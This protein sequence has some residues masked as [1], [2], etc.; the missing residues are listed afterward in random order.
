[1]HSLRP[2]HRLRLLLFL[3]AVLAPCMILV[4]LS[5][6][7]VRQEREL[8]EKRRVDEQRQLAREIRNDLAARLEAIQRDEIRTDLEPGQSYRHRE[9]ALVAWLDEDK[10]V[11]PWE[12]DR[13]A[14]TSRDLISKADFEPALRDC[15]RSNLVAG[16]PLASACF[17]QVLAAAKHP[18]QA[19]YA[20]FLWAD[21][22]DRAGERARAEGPFRALLNAGPELTDEDG[23]PLNLHAAQRFAESGTHRKEVVE[24]IRAALA[25][26]WLPPVACFLVSQVAARLDRPPAA[27][28]EARE[29][30]EAAAA[31]VRLVEQA[32]SLQNDFAR[33]G[34]LAV[35]GRPTPLWVSYG[36]ERW[37]VGAT[38]E[39]KP[40]AVIAVRAKELF[41]PIETR[42][43]VRF[44]AAGESLGDTFP[45]LTIVP[46]SAV[47][48]SASGDFERQ[49][50]FFT[51]LLV[52]A[53]TA[54]GAYLLWRDLRREM[55]AVELRAQFVASVSHELRTPLTAIRMFAETLQMGRSKDP[56]T[57]SEYL[58]TI[59][60]ECERLSRLVDGVL[61]FAKLEQ[62]KK[63]YHFRSVPVAEAVAAAVRALRYPLSQ[64][65][66][67]LQLS[68]EPDPLTIR[69]DRDALEQA[70]LNLLTNAMKYSGDAR[71]IE[72]SLFR[73][74]GDAVIRVTDHGV[75][76][77]PEAR[78]RI[79]EK[80][81][82]APT[83][84]NQL[85]PGTGLGLALVAH[86]VKAHGGRVEVESAP[87][88]GSTF[89]LHLPL[90]S[91]L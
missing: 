77:A 24:R 22:L 68:V 79:F 84:E 63:T 70:I 25:R 48:P 83:P 12:R 32:Q 42:R 59:V 73:H 41:Q 33:L 51:V 56:E 18:A 30:K 58:E 52:A 26:P 91:K 85:I 35:D 78:L 76:I 28:A 1:M 27:A 71:Q 47:T 72:L 31:H 64:Q 81:Y 65:G 43:A 53:A 39:P 23:V 57:A 7:I 54:F 34:L 8:R 10:L 11:L 69:A 89:S 67:D 19:A 86:I 40:T 66:F 2:G 50:L 62:G 4:A 9:V 38:G 6:Q 17:Q 45:G 80:F 46:V 75:G 44:A 36:D 61:L 37:L 20:R 3:G 49:L 21:A 5:I 82:R 74:D 14:R 60:N 88:R 90:Q 29:I 13:A 87:G 55:A 16:H 15:E